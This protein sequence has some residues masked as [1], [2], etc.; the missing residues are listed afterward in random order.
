MSVNSANTNENYF[1]RQL[2]DSYKCVQSSR[3]VIIIEPEE[4]F[5]TDIDLKLHESCQS[6]ATDV[7]LQNAPTY[8]GSRCDVPMHEQM[9]SSS[10]TGS[11]TCT[12]GSEAIASQTS[13][14]SVS[15]MQRTSDNVLSFTF[16]DGLSDDD[17]L[18]LTQT[19]DDMDRLCDEK[20]FIIST[21][22]TMNSSAMRSDCFVSC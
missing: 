9:Y 5:E 7:C 22:S 4:S 2:P 17:L 21:D 12:I 14:C 19:A 1:D 8:L 13:L 3:Q 16:N 10:C 18:A 11:I 15:D 6:D 20:A